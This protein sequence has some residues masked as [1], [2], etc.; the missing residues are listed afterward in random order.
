MNNY[1]SMTVDEL[2]SEYAEWARN[3]AGTHWEIHGTQG[4][5]VDDENP[6]N[7]VERKHAIIAA[8]KKAVIEE[9]SVGVVKL[10]HNGVVSDYDIVPKETLVTPE[11]LAY[12][13][14]EIEL[15]EDYELNVG[16]K[17]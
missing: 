13:K 12:M 8:I 10:S 3:E 6:L 17:P 7:V 5:V 9:A 1:D 15:H 4:V 16:K 11:E 14:R 2:M